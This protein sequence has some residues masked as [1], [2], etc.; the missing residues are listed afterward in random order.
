MKLVLMPLCVVF[1]LLFHCLFMLLL[2]KML[3]WRT[4]KEKRSAN[5]NWEG[6]GLLNMAGIS[7]FVDLIRFLDCKLP[8]AMETSW[9]RLKQICFYF[10][11]CC[12]KLQLSSMLVNNSA[13][14][15]RFSPLQLRVFTIVFEDFV[16]F[17]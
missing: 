6:S 2:D 17:L 14:I 9:K 11:K 1:V 15:F 3:L 8:I 13:S 12:F 7:A 10:S 16:P 4:V 5:I